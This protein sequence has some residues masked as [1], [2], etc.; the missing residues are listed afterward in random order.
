MGELGIKM[1]T[2]TT[3]KGMM[4]RCVV[5]IVA[6]VALIAVVCLISSDGDVALQAVAAPNQ[7]NPMGIEHAEF[8]ALDR[9]MNQFLQTRGRPM[10]PAPRTAVAAQA[11]QHAA[12]AAHRPATQ[13]TPSRL[14]MAPT[15][16]LVAVQGGGVEQLDPFEDDA[17]DMDFY[18]H[19]TRK[20]NQ[21]PLVDAME[22]GTLVAD[23]AQ[24]A[25][26]SDK[27]MD[28]VIQHAHGSAED[29]E[30][31]A[32]TEHNEAGG[33]KWDLLQPSN[34][35]EDT[36]GSLYN[37][38][39]NH[40]QGA[41]TGSG[42]SSD[43]EE[44]KDIDEAARVTQEEDREATKYSAS[45]GSNTGGEP[46]TESGDGDDGS[47]S[48]EEEEAHVH[49]EAEADL[50]GD[51]KDA[52]EDAGTTVVTGECTKPGCN[53]DPAV[54]VVQ[55]KNPL[56]PAPFDKVD[57]PDFEKTN[58]EDLTATSTTMKKVNPQHSVRAKLEA[59]KVHAAH[60][61]AALRKA[62]AQKEIKYKKAMALVKKTSAALHKDTTSKSH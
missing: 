46:Y 54:D 16:Q 37:G 50:P 14:Q 44:Q 38:L 57:D 21:D 7:G 62:T 20:Q 48:S 51:N 2:H 17:P 10:P 13:S 34:S 29:L 49:E 52:E 45:A 59:K 36:M 8:L 26:E 32:V 30:Q 25:T 12:V 53:N 42:A 9:D 33:G 15:E 55:G 27:M 60:K 3:Q 23:E 56:H 41:H 43:S 22:D 28:K 58:E 61:I 31:K 19:A 40:G 47:E 6:G 18:D 5:S 39:T 24:G 4:R 1:M 35:F 11:M